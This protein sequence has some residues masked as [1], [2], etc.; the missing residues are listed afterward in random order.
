MIFH[1]ASEKRTFAR[2]SDAFLI[3]TRRGEGGIWSV[4]KPLI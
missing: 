2:F 4:M 3:R 1:P